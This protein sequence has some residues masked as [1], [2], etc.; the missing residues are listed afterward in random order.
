MTSSTHDAD[1]KGN[2][3][4]TVVSLITVA[5]IFSEL[6]RKGGG[7]GGLPEPP[8]GPEDRKKARSG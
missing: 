4:I 3:S 5:F 7:G 6:D 1:L 2:N 8:H